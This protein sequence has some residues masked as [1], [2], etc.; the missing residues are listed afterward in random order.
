MGVGPTQWAARRPHPYG[1]LAWG[2]FMSCV[3]AMAHD[4]QKYGG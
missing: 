4:V 3:G 1:V 2:S